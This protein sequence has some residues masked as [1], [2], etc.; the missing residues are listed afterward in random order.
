MTMP[1]LPEPL[2]QAFDNLMRVR[3]QTLR[4]KD[5]A[6]A[7]RDAWQ[8]RRTQVRRAMLQAMGAVPEKPAPLEAKVIG[9][10]KR[11]GYRIEKVIFQSRPDMWVSSSLYVPD[12]AR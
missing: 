12:N 4:A 8:E 2:P 1:V 3:G 7:N 6:P 9:V 11:P 10:L 5:Q